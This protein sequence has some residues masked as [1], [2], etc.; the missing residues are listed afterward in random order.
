M[1][2]DEIL[3]INSAGE[4]VEVTAEEADELGAFE[5]TAISEQEAIESTQT[6]EG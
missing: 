5:E 4:E 3:K 2:N 1:I 6:D